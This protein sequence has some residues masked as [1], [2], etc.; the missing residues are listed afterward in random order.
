MNNLFDP[1]HWIGSDYDKE[2]VEGAT[3]DL[4]LLREKT[5]VY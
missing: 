3:L 5:L 2:Q 1:Q 4:Q